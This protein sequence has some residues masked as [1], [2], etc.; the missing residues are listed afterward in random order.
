MTSRYTPESFFDSLSLASKLTKY[1]DSFERKEIQLFS[2]FSC[3]LFLYEGNPQASWGHQYSVD[4]G[5]PF[6]DVLDEAFERHLLNG[7]FEEE[8]DNQY[9]ISGRGEQEL[10]RFISLT[11]FSPREK[12]IDAAC[13]TSILV[14]YDKTRKALL[15]EPGL[16]RSQQLQNHDWLQP[17]GVYEDFRV[18]SQQIGVNSSELVVPAVTWVSY[19]SAKAN[20]RENGITRID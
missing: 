1:L 15:D 6:C 3:L 14:P 8:A 7:N 16:I 17:S 2:F 11:Q 12:Y 13:A 18:I 9:S 19:L 4:Q 10:S 5:F 20:T